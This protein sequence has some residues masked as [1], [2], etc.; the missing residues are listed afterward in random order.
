MYGIEAYWEK[1]TKT[2]QKNLLFQWFLIA[3]KEDA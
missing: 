1:K 3:K 2:K